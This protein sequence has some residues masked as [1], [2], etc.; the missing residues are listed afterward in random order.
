MNYFPLVSSIISAV[1]ALL[2]AI[3]YRKRRKQHQLIWAISL[4]MFFLTTLLEFAAEFTFV[5][6]AQSLGW[7]EL[8]Y[9]L[10][11]VLSPVMVAL[12]GAGSLYLLAHVPVG[13]YFLSYTIALAV[14]LFI[15]GF[16]APVGQTL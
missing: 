15:A 11:Y 8:T 5:T 2:L 10:Y 9:K 6:Y 13:K 4:L 16:V 1:F 12:M 7:N 14:P 3:Q